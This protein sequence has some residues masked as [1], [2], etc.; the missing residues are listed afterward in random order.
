MLDFP[1]RR[2]PDFEPV[3]HAWSGVRVVKMLSRLAVALGAC[4][5]WLSLVSAT[6]AAPFDVEKLV[7]LRRLSDPQVSP[8]GRWVVFVLRETDRAADKGWTDLWI[9][10]ARG[11]AAARRITSDPAADRQPRWS[12]DGRRLYFLSARSGSSQVWRLEPGKP[13]EP[14]QVTDLELGINA[15]A[16]APAEDRLVVSIE[17]Y[18][19]CRTLA[20][21]RDRL[22]ELESSPESARVFDRLM[23]RHWDQWDD[24]RHATLHAVDP[25]G[26]Q[27]PVALTAGMDAH[28]PPRPFG[29]AGAFAI[30]ADGGSVFFVARSA[31]GS[32]KAWSTNLDLFRVPLDGS[33]PPKNLT[34]ALPGTEGEPVPSPDGRFLAFSS[35]ARAGFEADRHRLMLMDLESGDIRELAGDLDRSLGGFVWTQGSRGIL[36]TGQHLGQKALFRVDA[37]SGNARRLVD[38]GTVA[39]VRASGG[40]VVLARNDLASPNDLYRLDGKD[41][42]RLT[43]VNEDLLAGVEFG[44]YE[45]FTFAGWNDETVHAYVVKPAGFQ[46]DRRY[47]LAFLVHGGPQ[48][49]FGNRFH[50][51]W[52]PQT[53]SGKGY[54]AVMVDFHG[55]TGYG[56][57]FTDS[58]SGD[59]GGKP[60]EDL[61]KGLAA[62]LERYPWIDPERKCA[63]GA[64]Y[65]GY[66]I[67]WI[68]GNWAGEFDC[69]VNHDGIF[70]NRSMY[71]TTEELWFVEWEHGGPQFVSP[72]T[73]ERH[74]P[75]NHVDRWEDPMLVIHGALDYRVPE[76]QGLA[77]FTALQRRGIPSRLVWFPDE[78][79]WVLRPSNSVRWHREVERWLGEWTR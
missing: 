21:T 15:F 63:L 19:D 53:Y 40:S 26:D 55:S 78:N 45:Q 54:V 8:D 3:N 62:A 20:C 5:C 71:Y 64:S 25:G 56:Q 72:G 14:E 33:A 28:V 16:V 52:N 51:R 74:N 75:V 6:A 13:S 27:T 35:M 11:D 77:A 49:S 1:A 44:A 58:I 24:G 66:M 60:L 79:H 76:T 34:A 10:P 61:R 41:L 42:T 70:D 68:A 32:E 31:A 4:A 48:G 69:L 57:A 59:W 47:P 30:A 29:D 12:G 36:A 67:N 46:A 7:D 65:G 18:P 43:A 39:A 38:S 17:V 73:Y 22:A 2:W 50:Y 9:V 37:Q 23:V